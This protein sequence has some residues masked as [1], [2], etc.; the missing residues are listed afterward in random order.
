LFVLV[1]IVKKQRSLSALSKF[2][3][4]RASEFEPKTE[5]WERRKERLIVQTEKLI[6]WANS[7]EKMLETE[8]DFSSTAKKGSVKT[9][10][11]SL[12]FVW[13]ETDE[14]S[15]VGKRKIAVRFT[16]V[17]RGSKSKNITLEFAPTGNVQNSGS[18]MR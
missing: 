9:T 3:R 14:A 15:P 2:T 1:S 5:I 10:G 7:R 18:L 13:S 12:L 4:N 6:G 11:D 8:W 16:E 17:G